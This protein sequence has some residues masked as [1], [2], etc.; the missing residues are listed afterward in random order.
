MAFSQPIDVRFADLDALG[1]VNHAVFITYLEHAR[2][3]WWQQL[4]AGRRFEEEGF[5]MARA[6]IDY[7]KPIHLGDP[8]RV[9]LR[10]AHLGRTSFALAYQVVRE[11]DGVLLAEA[12]TVQVM[13]DFA[14]LRPRA[15]DPRTIAWLKTQQ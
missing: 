4:L 14:T 13:V 12:Q 7:R 1:H 6:E 11:G 3:K 5:V 10:C 15:L 2:T 8:V 9:D